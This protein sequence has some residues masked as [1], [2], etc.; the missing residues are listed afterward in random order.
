MFTTLENLLVTE[1]YPQKV[2]PRHRASI[3]APAVEDEYSIPGL[4]ER[5]MGPEDTPF[6]VTNARGNFVET[7]LTK[8]NRCR[9][10]FS[11]VPVG[12]DDNLLLPGLFSALWQASDK[13]GWGNRCAN[14]PEAFGRMAQAGL[15]AKSLVLPYSMVGDALGSA[16][17]K[18]SIQKAMATKGRLTVLGGAA[19]RVV[20]S[21]PDG[22]ALIVTGAPLVGHYTRVGDYVGVLLRGIDKSIVLVKG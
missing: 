13:N 19:V 4:M 9:Y 17:D 22:C 11:K 8:E 16:F 10:G 5:D 12:E 6:L 21:M 3:V 20:E 1:R 2:N 15:E 7:R 18:E 14:I